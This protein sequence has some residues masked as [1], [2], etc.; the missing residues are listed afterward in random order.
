[1]Y[2]NTQVRLGFVPTCV[3]SVRMPSSSTTTISPGSMSRTNA[4][5]MASSAQLSDANTTFSPILPMHSGRKPNGS[6]AAIS[7]RGD[8]TTIEYA[9]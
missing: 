5:P 9:P 6:R 7:L 8:M 3:R 4:A 1:M 2:S